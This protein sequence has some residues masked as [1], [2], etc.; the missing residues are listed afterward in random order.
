L[1]TTRARARRRCCQCRD[2]RPRGSPSAPP[3]V[4]GRSQRHDGVSHA[5]CGPCRARSWPRRRSLPARVDRIGSAAG[6]LRRGAYRARWPP[7][8]MP[9]SSPKSSVRSTSPRPHL[10]DRTAAGYGL[11]EAWEKTRDQSAIRRRPGPDRGS[12]SGYKGGA[13]SSAHRPRGARV[14]ARARTHRTSTWGLRNIVCA[15]DFRDI[16]ATPPDASKPASSVQL[17]FKQRSSPFPSTTRRT[18]DFQHEPTRIL[19][20]SRSASWTERDP[21]G[22]P[23]SGDARS[24]H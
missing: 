13:T 7:A 12:L 3:S 22:F 10:G 20:R 11:S 21:S 18:G 17:G 15:P 16:G 23:S 8:S 1:T 9:N 4:A 6:S 14:R 24:M 19:T 5:D 2:D